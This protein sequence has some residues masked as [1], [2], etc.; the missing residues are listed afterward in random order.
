M[1]EGDPNGAATSARNSNPL[2][3]V[4]VDGEETPGVGADLDAIVAPPRDATPLGE[5]DS[6]EAAAGD[7]EGG[8]GGAGAGVAAA[9][10]EGEDEGDADG[11][12]AMA[13][14]AGAGDDGVEGMD[15]DF[16]A[17]GGGAAPGS[18]DDDDN[19]DARLAAMAATDA[20]AAPPEEIP[21]YLQAPK[22][23][24]SHRGI[25]LGPRPPAAPSAHP[26]AR[27]VR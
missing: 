16:G 11:A 23:K 12:A 18:D 20:P 5:E 14:D 21:S 15:A 6:P 25:P 1:E 22:P 19:I 26:P 24:K 3:L 7:D 10:A 27:P 13:T 4:G 17:E 9:A 2:P 8:A